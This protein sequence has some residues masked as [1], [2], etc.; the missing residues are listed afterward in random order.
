M[1]KTLQILVNW[2]TRELVVTGSDKKIAN[3]VEEGFIKIHTVSGFNI[4]GCKGRDANWKMK[5]FEADFKKLDKDM[6]INQ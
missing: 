6:V 3:F 1:A 2:E 4:S 5:K